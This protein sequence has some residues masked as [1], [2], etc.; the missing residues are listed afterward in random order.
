MPVEVSKRCRRLQPRAVLL[1]P[2]VEQHNPTT[3]A[4]HGGRDVGAVKQQPAG[5]RVVCAPVDDTSARAGTLAGGL[6]GI[7]YSSRVHCTAI[8]ACTI[9]FAICLL[10]ATNSSALLLKGRVGAPKRQ[11]AQ[12]GAP[13]ARSMDV[14]HH[15][16]HGHSGGVKCEDEGAL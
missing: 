7:D 9:I 4:A 12:G 5:S 2:A 11:L 16:N 1:Q 15:V 6:V 14:G 8:A 13:V 3:D 10:Q